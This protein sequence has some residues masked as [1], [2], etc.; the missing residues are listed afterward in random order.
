MNDHSSHEP[1]AQNA[2]DPLIAELIRLAGPRPQ[3]APFRA[4]RVRAVVEAEWRRSVQPPRSRGA[5]RYIAAAAV[6]LFGVALWMGPSWDRP[7]GPLR[8]ARLKPRRSAV[9]PATSNGCQRAG[10]RGRSSQVIGS[11]WAM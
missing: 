10:T 3:P 5:W 7:G 6:L 8:S 1:A 4:A 11:G 2:G 9:S